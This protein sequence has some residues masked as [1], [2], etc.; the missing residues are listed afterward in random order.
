MSNTTSTDP[1]VTRAL[2]AGRVPENITTAWLEESRDDSAIGAIIFVTILTAVIVLS[3]IASRV[4]VLRR[5]GLDDWLALLGLALLIAFVVLGIKLINIGS[6][7]HYEYIMYV[8]TPEEVDLSEIWDF[9]AHIVYTIALV[10]CRMS[11]LA[12][13]HRICGI[14]R[15]FRL[16]IRILMGVL[17]AGFLPQLFLIIFHCLPV[18]GLWPYDWQKDVEKY[19]CLQWGVVYSVNSG[20]SLF[21]DVLLFGIPLAMIWMLDLPRKRRLQLACIL[22]PG[23]LVIGISIARLVLVIEGQWEMDMSWTYNPMLAVEVS[24][25][26]ATLIS[27]SIPGIKPMFDKFIGRTVQDSNTGGQSGYSTKGRG[28]RGTS[29]TLRDLSLRPQHHNKLSSNSDCTYDAT[30]SGNRDDDGT[31]STEGIMVRV[32]F[33]LT[34]DNGETKSQ[35]RGSKALEA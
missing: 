3:R 2:Q 32:D 14:H 27:L 26:G 31:G 30:K 20:M 35:H 16:A 1:R 28:T 11:G 29:I 17:V 7:R 18:T 15:G 5:T 22:L 24:E 25:I 21:C 19:K 8:L 6:G 9:A 34:M 13:Y 10:M 33:D 4:L 12:F 23:I